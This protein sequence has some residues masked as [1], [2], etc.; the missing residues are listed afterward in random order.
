[1]QP[2]TSTT[3]TLLLLRDLGLDPASPAASR[4][5]DLVANSRWE[6]A[7]QR[8][9]SGEV[10]PCINGMTVAIGAYFGHHVQGIVDRL[11]SEQLDDGGWN[12]EAENGSVRS[13]FHTTISVL[14]GLL[15]HERA[16]GGGSAAVTAARLSGQEY[17]PPRASS[18]PPPVHRRGRRSLLDAVLLPNPLALRRAAGTRP[19]A[20][21]RR[22]ARRAMQRGARPP[23]AAAW[24][25]R[26]LAAP[27]PAPW[28]GAL[29]VGGGRGQAQSVEHSSRTARAALGRTRR[30]QGTATSDGPSTARS[31]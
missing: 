2:W 29:R 9:F 4:A 31:P 19:P 14:D 6:H 26:P 13:S 22:R 17:L 27:E 25:R 10:E 5:V 16:T 7:G 20:Q 12:C 1:M 28:S 3:H 24:Q 11:L 21:R 23:R 18:V 15:E 8:Y 30:I